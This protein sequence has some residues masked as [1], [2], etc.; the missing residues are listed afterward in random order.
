MLGCK[1][2]WLL[3][4]S[5]LLFSMSVCASVGESKWQDEIRNENIF[6]WHFELVSSSNDLPKTH[7]TFGAMTTVS[8][9]STGDCG[10]G[11]GGGN[12]KAVVNPWWYRCNDERWCESE[13]KMG[14]GVAAIILFGVGGGADSDGANDGA[15]DDD[16]RFIFCR[17]FSSSIKACESGVRQ[18]NKWMN[19][20]RNVRF[21]HA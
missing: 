3:K 11:G 2:K 20:R 15:N 9:G 17:A 1:Y 21:F 16:L 7:R 6:M 4:C 10:E 18:R 12:G 5:S 8:I 14:G 13:A 19:A